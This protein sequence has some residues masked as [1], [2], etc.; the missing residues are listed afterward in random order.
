M[1]FWS[2]NTSQSEYNATR[3]HAAIP[4]RIIN[5]THLSAYFQFQLAVVLPCLVVDYPD[6]GIRFLARVVQ[7]ANSAPAQ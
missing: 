4:T 1:T 3:S 7:P 2:W 5:Q 6:M